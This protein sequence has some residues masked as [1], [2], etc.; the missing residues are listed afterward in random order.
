MS[1]FSV[2]CTNVGQDELPQM[3]PRMRHRHELRLQHRIAKEQNVEIDGPRSPDFLVASSQQVLDPQ[4]PRHH[5]ARC[6]TRHLHLSD[7]VQEVKV[8]VQPDGLRLVDARQLMNDKIRLDQSP[9][10][11]QQIARPVTQVRAESDEC[12][13]RITRP[14]RHA[15]R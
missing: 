5:L 13:C 4:Q 15:S 3:H 9:D 7:L 6:N 1:F 8:S 2:G 14:E 11:K 12:G 10:A